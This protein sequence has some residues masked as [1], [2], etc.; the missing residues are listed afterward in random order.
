[1][2]QTTQEIGIPIDLSKGM[3]TNTIFQNGSL[4]LLKIMTDSDGKSIYSNYGYWESENIYI[5][6]KITSFK[7]VVRT[8]VTSGNASFKISVKT[9][10]DSFAWG[11]Y[12]E[13]NAD[14]SVSNIPL[15]WAKIKIEIIPEKANSNLIFDKFNDANTYT[16]EFV[17]DTQNYL[18]L[19]KDY[20]IPMTVETITEGFM[21]TKTIPKT[22]FKKINGLKLM[23]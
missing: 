12:V 5:Q 2:A 15:K 19:K 22:Q 1:V 4:Q 16:N 13:I 11:E 7:N 9:S 10:S 3:F 8:I 6:D 23:S 18:S 21:L 17:N 14:G 20:T